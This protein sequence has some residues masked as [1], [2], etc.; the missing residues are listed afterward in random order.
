MVAYISDWTGSFTNPSMSNAGTDFIQALY[1]A[2]SWLNST[3]NI[4]PNSV[5]TDYSHYASGSFYGGGSFEMYG[6]GF[7]TYTPTVNSLLIYTPDSLEYDFYGS[8]KINAITGAASGY[9]NHIIIQS[10]SGESVDIIGKSY[11]N[12]YDASITQVTFHIAEG[13]IVI[14]GALTYH[15][16]SDTITGNLNSFKYID[17]SGHGYQISSL[18]LQYQQLDA[19]PDFDSFVTSV[20]SGN[21][22]IKGTSN[23]DVLRGFGGN[24]TLNGGTNADILIGGTGNDTYLVDNAFDV[25]TEAAGE[26][27]DLVK[28]GITVAGG[29]YE[30]TNDVENA[31]LINTVAYNLTGNSLAN[32]LIGNRAINTLNGGDEN[33]TLDGKV[34]ADILIGGTGDDT[35]IIDNVGDAITENT[36]EGTDTVLSSA[37][38][39]LA[40]NIENLTL[41]GSTAINGKGNNLSNTITGNAGANTLDGDTNADTMIGDVVIDSTG[42]D[43]IKSSISY[44]LNTSQNLS[45]TG[46]IENLM[47]LDSGG[48][49]DATGNSMANKITGNNGYNTIDGGAGIDNLAG[50]LG[51]DTYIVD[52]VSTSTTLKLQDTITESALAG[53]D[54]VKLRGSGINATAV[55]LT[56]GANLENLDASQTGTTKLKLTGNALANTLTGNDADNSLN[57][58]VGDDKLY[59]GLGN[60]VLTGGA[61]ADQLFFNTAIDP[62]HNVDKVTDF[63]AAIDKFM[64][65][66]SVFTGLTGSTHL[67]DSLFATTSWDAGA[68]GAMQRILYDSSNGMLYYDADGNLND[69]QAMAFAQITGTTKPALSASDFILFGAN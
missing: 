26:G 31:S 25:V 65:D 28:V 8:L 38:Y 37:S 54:S 14:K 22:V 69:S 64:L 59:G 20:M 66:Y 53:I 45:L 2:S 21:D 41:T 3:P 61:G 60:D 35:Y 4:D 46:V 16:L 39:Q 6:S 18:S 42:I 19:Y 12:S 49:I 34:G 32:I 55:N 50:G 62:L 33:D 15:G 30:L 13:T 36:D 10:S 27:T 7:S 11:V 23:T 29:S 5:N 51:N 1:N 47:L 67:D 58:G 56:I 68:A 52:L 44:S 9:I 24:D 43:I 17:D 63:A 48:N 40:A 57:G